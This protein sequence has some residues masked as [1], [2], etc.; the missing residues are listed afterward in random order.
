MDRGGES[1]KVGES[2]G[3]DGANEAPAEQKVQLIA[4]AGEGAAHKPRHDATVAEVN[5]AAPQDLA[6]SV[7]D[8]AAAKRLGIGAASEAGGR[9]RPLRTPRPLA[10]NGAAFGL[11]IAVQGGKH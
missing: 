5:N 10:G 9:L 11:R 6:A 3:A 7:S 8:S 2:A 1:E 4:P